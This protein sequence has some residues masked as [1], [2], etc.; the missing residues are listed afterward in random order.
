[1]IY[2]FYEFF[3]SIISFAYVFPHQNL[4]VKF[5]FAVVPT[6]YFLLKNRIL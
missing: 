6:F 3:L 5:K 1:M 2:F 4:S